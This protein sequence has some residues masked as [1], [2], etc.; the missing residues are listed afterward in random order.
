MGLESKELKIKFSLYLRFLFMTKRFELKRKSDR[1]RELSLLLSD[2]ISNNV[3]WKD[4][5]MQRTVIQHLMTL[6]LYFI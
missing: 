5:N 6:M 4:N 1:L 2:Q 3:R